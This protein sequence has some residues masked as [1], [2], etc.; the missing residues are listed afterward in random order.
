MDTDIQAEQIINLVKINVNDFLLKVKSS[1]IKSEE[2]ETELNKIINESII[3]SD[4]IMPFYDKL[5]SKSIRKNVESIWVIFNNIKL[6]RKN[7]D[8]KLLEVGI[9]LDFV[10]KQFDKL[11]EIK[12]DIPQISSRPK[13]LK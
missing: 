3:L 5:R 7:Y 8:Q 1:V 2:S 12:T 13:R 6:E 9:Y 11:S 10:K 4:N